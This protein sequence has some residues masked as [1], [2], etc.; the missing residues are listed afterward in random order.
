VPTPAEIFEALYARIVTG[1]GVTTV[2]ARGAVAGT[3]T[4]GVPAPFLAVLETIRKAAYRITDADIA[5]LSA[6][7]LSDDAIYEL[8]IATTAGVAKRR[9]DSAMAAIAEASK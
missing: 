8:T 9:R 3:G 4:D 7:G 5:A 1:D 2:A 6:A